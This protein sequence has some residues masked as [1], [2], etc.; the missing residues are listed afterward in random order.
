MQITDCKS[1]ARQG[2]GSAWTTAAIQ[3]HQFQNCFP[4]FKGL[5]MMELRV[6]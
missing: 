4:I 2:K 5:P 3:A 1:Q 6:M